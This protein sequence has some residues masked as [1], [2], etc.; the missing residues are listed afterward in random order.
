MEYKFIPTPDFERSYKFLLKKYHSLKSDIEEFKK[1]Y[2]ENPN[3]GNDLGEGFRKIRIAIK[4]KNK[5]KRSGA[6]II[7]Y[8]VY[9]K[10]KDKVIILVDI[11]DKSEITMLSEEEYKIVLKKFLE[12][13]WK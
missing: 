10:T 2:I 11:Y 12:D 8:D 4:S 5:G 1:E 3:I 6:R 7:T 9:V 13:Y